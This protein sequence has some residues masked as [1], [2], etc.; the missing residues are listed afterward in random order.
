[1]IKLVAEFTSVF[2]NVMQ[3]LK[4]KSKTCIHWNIPYPESVSRA[5][6]VASAHL[7]ARWPFPSPDRV[8]STYREAS[9]PGWGERRGSAPPPSPAPWPWPWLRE[10]HLL[11][12]LRREVGARGCQLT[13]PGRGGAPTDPAPDGGLARPPAA[14][15]RP[16]RQSRACRGRE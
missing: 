9:A 14:P 11:R 7:P 12:P 4:K 10:H 5:R 3:P 13:G 2:P 16:H 1:M 15:A 6:T 8:L